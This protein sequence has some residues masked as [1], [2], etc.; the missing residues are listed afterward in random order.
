MTQKEETK[1]NQTNKCTDKHVLGQWNGHYIK[2][3]TIWWKS[4]LHALSCHIF[5]N[6]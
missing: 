6:M 2:L 1:D 3:N 5:N 4:L